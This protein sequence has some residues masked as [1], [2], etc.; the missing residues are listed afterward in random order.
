MIL[1]CKR[2]KTVWDYKGKNKYYATCPHCLNK[3][4][5][6]QPDKALEKVQKESAVEPAPP[7]PAQGTKP[8]PR[9]R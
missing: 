9:R 6:T 1:K 7:K 4:R 8:K 3:V 5:V 2:C